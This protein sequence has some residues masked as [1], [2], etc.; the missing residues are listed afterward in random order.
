MNKYFVKITH[1][2]KTANK[3]EEAVLKTYAVYDRVVVD[4][5]WVGN[6]SLIIDEEINRLIMEFPRCNAK[7]VN[8]TF[9]KNIANDYLFIIGDFLQLTFYHVKEVNNE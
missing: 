7:C 2:N 4:E 3:L 8:Y 9:S 5:F 1:Q 6:F